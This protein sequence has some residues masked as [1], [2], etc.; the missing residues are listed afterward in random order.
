MTHKKRKQVAKICLEFASR[1]QSFAFMP[2]GIVCSICSLSGLVGL[3]PPSSVR[4][5][6]CNFFATLNRMGTKNTPAAIRTRDPLLRS[7]IRLIWRKFL[8]FIRIYPYLL[9][10]M[11]L[12]L[13]LLLDFVN[14]SLNLSKLL[15]LTCN[16]NV[17]KERLKFLK[18]PFYT[19]V[20]E[21]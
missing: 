1:S 6:F 18:R 19:R 14:F 21:G 4:K 12:R 2:F 10:H 7:C 20:G 3:C 5:N 11:N 16:R 13:F 8:G 9:Q 17:I 15:Q